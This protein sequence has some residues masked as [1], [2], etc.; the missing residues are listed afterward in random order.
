MDQLL[1]ILVF[2]NEEIV[3]KVEFNDDRTRL[4]VPENFVHGRDVRLRSAR[5]TLHPTSNKKKEVC[6]VY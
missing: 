1:T 6:R 3:V 4:L 5:T 2:L